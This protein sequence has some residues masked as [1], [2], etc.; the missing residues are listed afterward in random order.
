MAKKNPADF[1]VI[2]SV[3]LLTSIGV[4][5]VFSASQY[6]AGIRFNDD[7]YF[8]KSQLTW[9][10]L[11]FIVMAITS[12][13][14]YKIFQKYAKV[15]LIFCIL[16]LLA[17]FIPG[18]G[19]NANGATRWIGFGSFT[20]QPSEVTKIGV[21]IFMADSLCKKKE[22]I[23]TFSKGILPYILLVGFIC[24]LIILQPNLSTS[25]VIAVIIFSMLFV[26]G[27]NLKYFFT[28]GAVA[29]PVLFLLIFSADYRRRRFTSFLDPWSDMAGDGYQIIQSLLAFGSGGLFGQGLGNG[30]QKL[31][32]IPEPQN[33]FI[34]A[35]I[36]EELGLIG[37][38]TI[39]LLFMLLIWRGIRIALY[40]PD[41]FASLVAS[42]I[43]FM[44]AFQVI[45]NVGVAT[46]MMPVTGM[47]LPF[48]SAGGSSL[49]FLMGGI[50][51]LLNI[52]RYTV[53]ERS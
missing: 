15:I 50:G 27:V 39:L 33:D 45:I 12:K 28:L 42:G 3:V 51:I 29:M 43:V 24:G 47:P 46:S 23:R 32:Y 10:I 19:V 25:V 22:E 17:V 31:L 37:T 21:I 7:L 1:I 8:L 9:S 30:K 16:L 48:I 20:I 44:I 6:S 35:H 5:M 38:V 2:F 36:G 26:A 14:H 41:M 18:L 40:A 52:S 49:V 53:L 11:G 13:I 34:F 4:I